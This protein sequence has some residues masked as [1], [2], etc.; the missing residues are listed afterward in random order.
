MNTAPQLIAKLSA[1]KPGAEILSQGK[2]EIAL[3]LTEQETVR[4][5]RNRSYR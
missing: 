2:D 4:M 5:I 3:T 1:S